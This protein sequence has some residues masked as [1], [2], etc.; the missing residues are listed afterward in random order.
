MFG[1]FD[2]M[3]LFSNSFGNQYILVYVDYM[4]KW[5]EVI[6]SK[7]NDNKIV[8]K[9]LKENIFSHFKMPRSIISDKGTHFCNSS[10]EALIRKYVITHMLSTSYN[11]QTSG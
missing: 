6:P 3:G 7:M 4:S 9:F 2:F 5:V 1:A 8:V 10:F 11:P